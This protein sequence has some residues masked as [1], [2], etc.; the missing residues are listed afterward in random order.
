MSRQ[1][2]SWL[3]AYCE[4]CEDFEPPV[5]YNRWIGLIIL[6]VA[7]G[8]KIW[9]PEANTAIYPN[10]YVILSGPSGAGK[11]SA[12][13]EALPFIAQTG[14]KV[15]P[16][17]VTAARLMQDLGESSVLGPDGLPVTPYLIYSEEFPAFLGMQ[18]YESGLIADLT[19]LY[20]CPSLLAKETKSQGF[21]TIHNPYIVLCAGT[22]PQGTFDV[23]PPGTVCQGFTA[24]LMFVHSTYSGKPVADKPWGE[25][26]QKL[27]AFLTADLA[28]I[29]ALKG[30]MQVSPLTK[31]VWKDYYDLGRRELESIDARIQGYISRKPFYARKL[32]TLL[33]LAESDKMVIESQH[34]EQAIKILDELDPCVSEVYLQIAPSIIINAQPKILG[35]LRRA[36]GNILER[37][38]LARRFSYSLDVEQLDRALKGLE[39][40]ELIVQER[41]LMATG[42]L[43]LYYRLTMRG[44]N[45][46]D[47]V[48][49]N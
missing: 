5:I 28:R 37:S 16:A 6:S 15:S 21:D 27:F 7:A 30:P 42:R 25:K 38:A 8:R 12:M 11:T 40:Q 19:T 14:I 22:T 9:L 44:M 4:Y 32:M 49:P 35:A 45:A 43:K 26:Q 17:K 39:S 41:K 31:A 20:D 23:L 36:D 34:L 29:M 48:K 24:R 13:R 10:L 46:Y 18:A 3:D 1:L 33:S 47:I 2:T